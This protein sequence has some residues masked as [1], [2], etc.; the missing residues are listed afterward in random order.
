MLDK[1]GFDL[2][3]KIFDVLYNIKNKFTEDLV[4]ELRKHH[5]NRS[6]FVSLLNIYTKGSKS[7]GGLC[8]HV[9]LRLGSLTTVIDNLIEKGFVIREPDKDDR[10]KIMVNLTEKGEK[11]M[12]ELTHLIN[13]TV[14]AKIDTLSDEEK[15]KF[16][17]AIS[18]LENIAKKL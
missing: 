9:D 5:I 8:K 15:T 6:E 16:L 10:R 18:T 2:L 1:K 3:H 11:F 4:S 17:D 13:D 7:M 12:R 14:L